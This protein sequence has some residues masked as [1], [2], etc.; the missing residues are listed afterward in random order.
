MDSIGSN[1]IISKN[2]K[3]HNCMLNMLSKF[4]HYQTKEKKLK[5]KKKNLAT[6]CYSFVNIFIPQFPINTTIKLIKKKGTIGIGIN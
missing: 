5:G 4:S 6:S 3:H 1:P 2:L